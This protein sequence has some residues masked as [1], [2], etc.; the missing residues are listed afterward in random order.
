[1][2]AIPA[3]A[4]V[5]WNPL[6]VVRLEESSRPRGGMWAVIRNAILSP[7]P[8]RTLDQFYTALGTVLE[9]QANHAAHALGLGPHV[10]DDLRTSVPP[11]LEKRCFKL[12]KYTLPTESA[13]TQRQSFK[14]IVNLSLS[15][16][17]YGQS[18]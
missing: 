7:S 13:N 2:A 16:Q 6:P 10:L 14:Y 12:L 4:L 11:Q 1:M 5:L 15:F 9:K 3:N 18:L 8:G 17:D